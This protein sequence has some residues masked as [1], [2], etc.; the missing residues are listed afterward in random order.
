MNKIIKLLTTELEN[1]ERLSDQYFIISPIDG[2]IQ[3]FQGY[4]AGSLVLQNQMIAKISPDAEL[5]AE[6]WITPQYVGLISENQIVNFH[7]DAFN[8]REWGKIIG[9][10]TEISDDAIFIE[11]RPYFKVRCELEKKYLTLKNGFQGNLKKGMTLTANF[12]LRKRS[13]YNLLFDKI[14]DWV[15]PSTN[16]ANEEIN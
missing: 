1:L 4:Q 5:L 9:K 16:I 7:I 15:N 3:E 13:L 6:V 2:T 8:Y 12:V 14:D 11:N 10:V